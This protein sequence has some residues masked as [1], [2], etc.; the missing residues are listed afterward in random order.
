MNSSIRNQE[1]LAA[2]KSSKRFFAKFGLYLLLGLGST[3]SCARAATIYY[4][5]TLTNS[6][7]TVNW[8]T[9]TTAKTYDI[10]GDNKYGSYCV[11]NWV[12]ANAGTYTANSISWVGSGPQYRQPEYVQ[13]NDVADAAQGNT[14]PGALINNS[15]TNSNVGIALGNNTF[16]VNED[17]TGKILRVGVVVDVLGAAEYPNE[18]MNG[19]IIHQTAGGSAVSTV[20]PWPHADGHP[21]MIFFDIANAQVGDQYMIQDVNN[22]GGADSITTLTGPISW[23]TN[24]IS[25]VSNAPTILA[26][27]PSASC[28]TG[29]EY[30]LGVLAGG[31]PAPTYQWYQGGTLLSGATN[32]V[33][34]IPSASTGDTGAYTVT[35][36]TSAGSVTSAPVNL[37][38]VTSNLPPTLTSY[39]AAVTAEPSL[40]SYYTFDN[41]AQ[42]SV[43]GNPGTFVGTPVV[44]YQLGQG[45]GQGL[46][47]AVKL[48]A[49][50]LVE[51]GAVPAMSFPSGNGTIEAW[52]QASP[53][54]TNAPTYSPCIFSCRSAAGVTYSFHMD[55]A[56]KNS[57]GLWNGTAYQSISIPPAGSAW[58]HIGIIIT[59][60]TWTLIW[61]GVNMGTQ[62]QNLGTGGVQPVQIGNSTPNA[63]QTVE[64]W[65][66]SIDEVSFFSNALSPQE[67]LSHY[68]AFLAGQ[69]PI[70]TAQPKSENVLAGLPFQLG[71]TVGGNLLSYQW[72]M[73]NSALPAATSSTLAFSSL[74]ATNAGSYFCVITNLAGAVTSSPAILQ[75]STSLSAAVSAYDSAV[76]SEPGLISYYKFDN[77][78]ANDSVGTNN[79]TLE[80]KAIFTPGFGG[81]PD[82]AMY[83]QGNGWVNLGLVPDFDFVSNVGTVE[84]WWRADW[85]NAPG[86]DPCLFSDRNDGASLVNYSLHV[87]GNKTY[88]NFW[89][90][91]AGSQIPIAP[92]NVWHHSGIIFDGSGIWTMTLDGQVL[93]TNSEF[94]TG[95]SAGCQI[96]SSGPAGKEIWIG[97]LSRVAYYSTALTPAQLAAHYN[98]YLNSLP[99]SITTQP[100]GGT[101]LTGNSFALSVAAVGGNLNYQWYQNNAPITGNSSSL[102]FANASLTNSGN[103]FVVITNATGSVTSAVVAV[104]IVQPAMNAYQSAV[105]A[106]PGLIS[107][108]DFD[109]DNANDQVGTNNG[110]FITTSAF[111]PGIGGGT[112][113]ALLLDGT[114]GAVAFGT[115]PAFDFPSG[116]GTIELWLRA[117]WDSGTMTYNPAIVSD[118]NVS[119]RYGA[120]MSAQKSAIILNASASPSYT[121]PSAGT[122]WNYLVIVMNSPLA[123]VYWNGQFI[124]SQYLQIQAAGQTT[125]LGSSWPT[126][127]SVW[128]G[129]MDDVAFYSTSLT[130]TDIASHYQTMLGQT[131]APVILG[132][133]LNGGGL[134]ITWPTSATGLV[135]QQTSNLST[136]PWTTVT[137]QVNVVGSQNQVIVNPNA[138]QQ[139]YRL[140]PQ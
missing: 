70:I 4:V 118:A 102:A 19:I 74:D 45:V 56:A 60:G 44:G 31:A 65:I 69:P 18:Q 23:D 95:V 107:F 58:H 2:R 121:I 99:L 136:G 76:T 25:A 26:V 47:K 117:D 61:D 6:M 103:Y 88:V 104:S 1:R 41:G 28:L 85:T 119:S 135:L 89:N 90:G 48:G 39:R 7:E 30:M 35:A 93:G 120:V 52:I 108:Y 128:Q 14:G 63:T 21:D 37:T 110:T 92:G 51:L 62:T 57:I 77:L 24:V 68:N 79:G 17:L 115:V 91:N 131:T 55:G 3:W 27:S 134:A 137:N 81:G 113:V 20:A 87:G 133:S 123:A 72:Y 34:A 32:A 83:S 127:S 86:Y 109:Q 94:N 73:N 22:V 78:N 126:E 71:V 46:D 11:I 40:I 138:S 129:A 15:P 112:N 54:W 97:A 139:F 10:D 82:Q 43:G 124:G 98:D 75:V 125:Q 96:G 132:I 9:P 100:Q 114:D 67:V 29:S 5:G 122:N 49:D 84:L 33:Y 80:N 105:R 101:Y 140:A 50:G 116:Q 13:I 130:A 36:V 16:Q 111:T 38:V 66:G 53:N 59:N 12:E 64:D 8:L 42:D 106:E